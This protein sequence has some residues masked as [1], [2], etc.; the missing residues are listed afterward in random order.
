MKVNDLLRSKGAD[1]ETIPPTATIADAARVLAI[2]HIGA[3]VV[4][5]DGQAIEGI[6]SE[7]DIVHLMADQGASSLDQPV[8]RAMTAEV[9]T[10][11][12]DDVVE[13]LMA[14][15]TDHRIRHLPVATGDR[16]DG[17]IS[18]GDVVKHRVQQLETERQ[19]LTEYIQTGR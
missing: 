15:M 8:S 7:R 13:D 17:I 4:S 12:R 2:R 14:V 16:L 6:L 1:V 9:R 3:L 10:C 11:T 5:S 18:I 19:Q